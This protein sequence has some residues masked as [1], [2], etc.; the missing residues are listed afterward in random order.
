MCVAQVGQVA[1]G[2]CRAVQARCSILQCFRAAVTSGS[3]V[4]LHSDQSLLQ[5]KA[6][7]PIEAKKAAGKER[8]WV[9]NAETAFLGI[10]S[11]VTN[12][13]IVSKHGL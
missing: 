1:L 6:V 5:W 8:N 7:L 11:I 3:W 10:V 13:T 4:S 2:A 12:S 9:S